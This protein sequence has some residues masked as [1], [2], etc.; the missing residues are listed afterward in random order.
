MLAR[1]PSD[2][3]LLTIL[4]IQHYYFQ[5]VIQLTK[6]K[7]AYIA[8]DKILCVFRQSIIKR[9]VM[10]SRFEVT[11]R[12]FKLWLRITAIAIK[13]NQAKQIILI[14]FNFNFTLSDNSSNVDKQCASPVSY[15]NKTIIT[16]TQYLGHIILF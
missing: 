14:H 6:I 2:I 4:D 13:I 11:Q 7:R 1:G 8:E 15:K 12:M 10:A 5:S 16:M 3:T 9:Q